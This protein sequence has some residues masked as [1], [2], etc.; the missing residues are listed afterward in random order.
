MGFNV[1]IAN[2]IKYDSV[3]FIR[4]KFLSRFSN[5]LRSN[6]VMGVVPGL[7]YKYNFITCTSPIIIFMVLV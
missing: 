4:Y 6:N 3:L 7:V 2:I 5:S 1:E